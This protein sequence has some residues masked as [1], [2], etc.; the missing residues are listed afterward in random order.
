MCI[1][2]SGETV[3]QI[4]NGH[5]KWLESK[6]A[7][8]ENIEALK[9]KYIIQANEESY[10]KALSK[11][12]EVQ[13]KL[14]LAQNDYNKIAKECS[15]FLDEM[16][17]SLDDVLNGNVNYAKAVSYTHLDVYKRQAPAWETKSTTAKG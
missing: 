7:I 1:R 12:S 14:T 15:G 2:D 16:G 13:S 3:V 9:Q 5:L 8:L 10:T 11:Q 17:I 6:E 4:E